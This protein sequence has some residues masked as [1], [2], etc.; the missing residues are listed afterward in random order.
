M[1]CSEGYTSSLAA[2]ALRSLGL[3]RATDVVGGFLA[4]ARPVC[5]PRAGPTP[6]PDPLLA[7]RRPT[8]GR[9]GRP[10]LR[11]LLPGDRARPA[12]GG[13]RR[14][15]VAPERLGR[16]LDGVAERHGAFAEVGLDGD[17]AVRITCAD[18]TTVT[19]RAPFGWTP[20]PAPAHR[21]HR[22]RPG[23]APRRGAA[24]PP[25]P[26]GG[27]RLRRR[28]AGRLQGRRPA[29][30]GA[31]GGR[32]LVAAAVRPPARQPDR[33]RRRRTRSR[34]RRACCCRTPASVAGAVHRR[35]P[36]AGRR[37]PGRPAAG[38]AGR[39]AAGS[40]TLDVG[41]PTKAV[42]LDDAGPVPRRRRAHRGARDR[43]LACSRSA[44][45]SPTGLGG[46]ASSD[47]VLC[48]PRDD[49]RPRSRPR[50]RARPPGARRR[51]PDRD[52]RR[53]H[54]GRPT[55]ASTPGRPSGSA[56]PAPSG[57][58][59]LAA[60]P[61]VPPFFGRTDTRRARETF[62][63]GRRHVR[64]D[65]GD[66]VVIDWRAPMSRPF[67]QASAAD[68]QGLARRRRFGFA[69][70]EL[71][72]YEDELLGGRRR[73]TRAVPARQEIER[74][75]QRPDARHRRHHP[76][77][78]GRHRPR[79]A[80]RVDL[81]AGRARAPA[82]PRSACTAPPTCSTRT[83]G[84]WR[85]PAS[86]SSGP[87]RA[88]L[89]YIEQVLPT[90][91]EVDVDQTTVADLTARVPVRAVDR[92]RS[93]CS[94]A[95]PGW[96]R[97]CA[98]RCGARSR[99]P[100]DSIQVPLAGRKYRVPVERLKRYVDDLRRRGRADDDQ[101]L[102]HYAAG[103]ERLAMLLAEDARRQK[104]DAGGSPTDAETRRAARSAEVRAF[105]DEVWPARDAAG[106]GRARCWTEPRPARPRGP[107]H[108][109]RRRAGAAALAD[110][111]A[112]GAHRA[113]DRGRRRPGRRGRRAA[114]AH[115]PAT[116]TSSSTRRRTSRRCS[117][118]RSPA[119]WP[120]DR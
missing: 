108:P 40:R 66:P 14:L 49:H 39:A 89:R 54:R 60:D 38:A 5:R 111:A 114:G 32:R 113:V 57:C 98:G 52:A 83:A 51:L 24:G 120:P 22:R 7:R 53:R 26:L 94:R 84:S 35:R 36:R 15:G 117:A 81:R 28:R 65:A 79:A 10:R 18:T 3:H 104:E 47:R 69:G 90:L 67:Y 105:C 106:A 44:G 20:G 41:E 31:D 74:P 87:N 92:P 42:L 115:A 34:P 73:R 62:H 82:R 21:L 43:P 119:G 70:G 118:G 59:R 56:P 97:C 93:P 45:R 78:P 9:R 11:L 63:I 77:R 4:W 75:A 12:A 6:P 13:G 110:A 71:T 58:A 95:T 80:D 27:R 102:L 85:G 33:R 103:R 64:D 109:G 50:R 25:R 8:E 19:L 68:P 99:K 29:G 16:W 37:G 91:G 101:Q 96:P 107:R 112:V 116:A 2:D 88:F 72:G 76:A 86:W 30:P 55:P 61:G 100:A 1:L 17:G 23:A 46:V 48:C